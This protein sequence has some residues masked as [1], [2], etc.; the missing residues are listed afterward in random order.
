MIRM[1]AYDELEDSC[2]YEF[3]Y[4]ENGDREKYW[5]ESSFYL[6]WGI[7]ENSIDILMPYILKVLPEF[8]G[9]G[10]NRVTADEWERIRTLAAM[11]PGRDPTLDDFFVNVDRWLRAGNGGNDHFWIFGP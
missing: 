7:Q 11:D 3:S 10:P 5:A 1:L 2:V 9:Y 4:A 8:D 6:N